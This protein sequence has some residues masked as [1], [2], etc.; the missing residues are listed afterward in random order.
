MRLPRVIAHR[1]ASAYAPENT[2]SAF[3]K[4]L[5]LGAQGLELDVQLSLDGKLVVIH[6]E[7]LD[8]TSDGKGWVKDKTLEELKSLDFGSWF[9]KDFT[10]EK[11]PLLDEVM[12]LI[13]S[14][15]GLLNI[16]IKNGV[17]LNPDIEQK[18]A[19]AIAKFDMHDRVIVSS[20]NH[21]SLVKLRKIE[22][23][24]KT[25]ILYMA[26]I[27][28]P[29]NYAAQVGA[30]AIHPLFYSIQPEIMHGCIENGIMVNPW[31]VDQPEMIKAI[32]IAGVDGIITNVADV[33]LGVLGN[34][35]Q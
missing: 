32:V 26:G 22:S 7:K 6:D 15:D 28:E 34:I 16:E 33:A 5:E 2:M 13:S 19:D 20:F 35:K 23:K 27:Y 9:S 24:I 10:G 4:A 18:V 14:W 30:C 11:I 17:V 1:G 25:G 29:W 12:E 21:Y 3:K 31:T 8:R